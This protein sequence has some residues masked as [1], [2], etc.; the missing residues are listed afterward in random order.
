MVSFGR[1]PLGNADLG[2]LFPW[3]KKRRKE[4]YA[5]TLDSEL[6]NSPAIPKSVFYKTAG[7]IFVICRSYHWYCPCINAAGGV[8]FMTIATIRSWEY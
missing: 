4:F 7:I 6:Q 3:W 1:L 8:E 5:Q 2:I